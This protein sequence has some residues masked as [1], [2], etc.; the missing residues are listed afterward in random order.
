VRE[1]VQVRRCTIPNVKGKTLAQARRA[2]QRAGC[3][4][5]TV[6]SRTAKTKKGI[7]LAQSPGPGNRVRRGFRVNVVLSKG[8]KV[9]AVRRA[10]VRPP[11]PRFTG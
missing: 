4:L 1:P 9:K 3:R 8:V 11:A 7:V 6:G 10:V 2:I 5:G